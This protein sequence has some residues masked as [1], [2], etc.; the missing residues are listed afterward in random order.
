MLSRL[1]KRWAIAS[2][3]R[4]RRTTLAAGLML[5]SATAEAGQGQTYVQGAVGRMTDNEWGELFEDW[6]SVRMLDAYQFGVGVQ[7]EWPIW[8][9]GYIGIEGQLTAHAGTQNHLEITTPVFVR[10]PRPHSRFLPSLAYGL[11]LSYATEP[12]EIEIDR[13]GESTELLAHWFFELEF[14]NAELGWRPFVRLH[15]RSHAWETFGARTGSNAVFIG[16]RTTPD[17]LFR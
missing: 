6:G 2:S 10:T 4:R 13:T 16:L 14:G 12:P 3:R 17:R 8:R 9:L 11:G 5:V 7:R 1:R 15:H